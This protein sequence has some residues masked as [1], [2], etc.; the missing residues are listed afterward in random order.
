LIAAERDLVFNIIFTPGTFRYLR[1]FTR[2]LLQNSA[3]RFRL[4]ANACP[5][6]ELAL[7]HEFRHQFEDRVVEIRRLATEVLVSHGRALE[8]LYTTDDGGLF[9][10]MDS[11]IK[12]KGPYMDEYLS[13]LPR[14]AAVTGA[15][16]MF[17]TESRDEQA[18]GLSG[19]HVVADDGFVF[20]SSYLAL[21][22]RAAVDEARE[23]FGVRFVPY[24]WQQIPEAARD[25]LLAMDRGAGLY[26]TAKVLNVLLQAHG[27]AVEHVDHPNLAHIGGM[28]DYLSRRATASTTNG[29]GSQGRRRLRDGSADRRRDLASFAAATLQRLSDGLA[30][31]PLPPDLDERNTPLFRAVQQEVVD[32]VSTYST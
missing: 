13:R 2:S 20:G 8:E 4:V 28:S 21:Y 16:P 23:R 19:M 31:P 32:L 30:P 7:M 17:P 29:S 1:L 9:C 15:M 11:D 14:C 27:H 26:D 25:T 10:F 3:V 5:A 6:D 12:A 22:V 24:R 18:Y